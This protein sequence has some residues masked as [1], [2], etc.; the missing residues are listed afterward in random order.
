MAAYSS[1]KRV[2]ATERHD[3]TNAFEYIVFAGTIATARGRQAKL[4]AEA[5]FGKPT[6]A[7][8]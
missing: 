8:C 2:D 3:K 6:D 5:H 7:K 4:F 1:H